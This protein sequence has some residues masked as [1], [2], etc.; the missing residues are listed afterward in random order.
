MTVITNLYARLS[1]LVK[2]PDCDTFGNEY[3]NIVWR[4]SRTMPT[5]A[6]IEA[7]DESATVPQSVRNQRQVDYIKELSPE[8]TFEKTVGDM[9]DAL[10]KHAYG[11]ST[12]LDALVIKIN[13]IKARYPE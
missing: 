12:E 3:D 13:D 9:L 11:D 8:G 10:V 4:D 6:E 7:V 1:N 5:E 2:E